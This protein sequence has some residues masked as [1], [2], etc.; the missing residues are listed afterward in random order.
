MR[1]LLL[2]TLCLLLVSAAHA[3]TPQE[4][5]V[6][7]ACLMNMDMM[8]SRGADPGKWKYK[9]GYEICTRLYPAIEAKE[10][11]EQ[12]EAGREIREQNQ[13]DL[14]AVARELGVTP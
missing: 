6:R 5:N 9:R 13:K 4:I 12:E 11:T 3:L 8:H 7:M 10:L 2:T 14:K 1:V